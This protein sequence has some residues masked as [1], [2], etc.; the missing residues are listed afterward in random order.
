[1]M[2]VDG[3]IK[4]SRSPWSSSVVIVKKRNKKNRFC[5]DCRKVN[6]VI[7][8]DLDPFVVVYLDDIIVV[9]EMLET[10]M[11]ILKKV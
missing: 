7:G 5:I 9:G 8:P 1:M 6:E 10:H 3:I 2:L 4:P 11:V